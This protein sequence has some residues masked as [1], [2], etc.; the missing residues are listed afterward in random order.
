MVE[1]T[2]IHLSDIH[3]DRY[4]PISNDALFASI[5]LDIDKYQE[6]QVKKPDL[7]LLSGDIVRGVGHDEAK[8]VLE[9]QYDEAFLFLDNL[10]QDLF[11][12]DRKKIVIVP[13]NHDVNWLTSKQSM[14]LIDDQ[15]IISQEG[16]LKKEIYKQYIEHK[17]SIKWSWSERKFYKVKDIDLYNNRFL[18]FKNFY[19]QFYSIDE[20]NYSLDPESQVNIFDYP[21]FGITIVGL[22]SCF[23]NDHLSRAGGINP[24]CIAKLSLELREFKR[25][26][27]LIFALWHH[28]TSGGPYDVDYIDNTFIQNLIEND[29]KIGFHGHQHKQTIV[30]QEKNI[31]DDKSLLLVSAGSL[32]SGPNELPNGYRPQYNIININMQKSN[33][34]LTFHSRVKSLDSTF[35]NPIWEAGDFG[36][37]QKTYSHEIE[38]EMKTV[39]FLAEA[40]KLYGIKEYKKAADLLVKD[41][42]NNPLVRKILIDC[43]SQIEDYDLIIRYFKEPITNEEVV[44]LLNAAIILKDISI[45]NEIKNNNFI[46]Q[47]KDSSVK[48]LLNQLG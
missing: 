23:H 27:R 11:D 1:L 8:N 7:I 24:N 32:C 43:L 5:M 29:V 34:K 22:N 38:H 6:L 13:G 28:N 46:V 48:H 3:R 26:G 18:E 36:F 30:K 42:M 9:K 20:K 21:E 12:G 15:N 44:Y 33:V 19:E 40:E 47:S 31:I 25:K 17:S 35:D 14:E 37:K 4:D 41:D 2:I 45:I 39:N 10:A 16:L